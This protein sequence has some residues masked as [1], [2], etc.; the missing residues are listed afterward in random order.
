MTVYRFLGS[1]LT[2]LLATTAAWA[3]D[4]LPFQHKVEVFRSDQ[5]NVIAFTVR[6]EQPFL[7]EEFEKSNYLRLH[8]TDEKA[9]LVYPKETRF[10]Q[11]H[12]EFYGRLRG[13]GKVKLNLSYETVS[14]NLDGS[15]RVSTRQGTIEVTIPEAPA[16]GKSTGPRSIFMK[17]AEEQNEYFAHLLQYY[18]DE[19]FLQYCLLQSKARYGVNP[20]PIPKRMPDKTSLETGMYQLF[21]GS[22][23]MQ[24]SLQRQSL[25]AGS[26]IGDLNTHISA[27][28]PPAL[29]SNDYE[30]LLKD[31]IESTNIEPLVHEISKLIPAEQYFLHFHSMKSLGEALDLTK[32]WGNSLLRLYTV[33]AQDNRLVEKISEQLCLPRDELDQ[34]FADGVVTEVAITGT[35]PFFLEGTDLSVIFRVADADIFTKETNAWVEASKR[36]FPGIVSQSF[37]Y[38]GH[39]VSAHYT[40]DRVVS[41]FAV[42]H[43]EYAIYSNSHRAV[44]RIID[45]AAG[46]A[47]GLHDALDYRYITTIL[48]PTASKES[49][50]FFASEAFIKQLISPAAKVSQKRRLQCFNNLVMINNASLFFRLEYDRSPE[51]LSELIEGRFVDPGKI[52]C[53]HGG[54]YTFDAEGDTCACSLHNRLRYLTPNVELSVLQVSQQEAQEYERYKQR[55]RSFWQEYFNPIAVRVSIDSDVKMEMCVLPFA[56]GDMYRNLQQTVDQEPQVLDTARLAPSAI[57]SV[58]LVPGRKNAAEYLRLIPGIAEVVQEDPTLT[59]LSWLGDRLS[60]NFCDGETIL[61][62]DPTRLGVLDVPFMGQAPFPLQCA[63]A[64]VL[65]ATTLPVYVTIDFE[66]RQKAERLLT[67]FSERIFLKQGKLGPLP[68]ALDAYRLPD[69]KEH[70]MYV[71]DGQVYALTLRLHIALVGDQFVLSTRPEVLREVIDASQNAPNE[72]AVKAHMLVRF[73]RNG[74]ERLRD[75]VE[76]YWAEKARRACHRNIMSIY[77]L[78]KLYDAAIEDIPELSQAKYGVRYF[79]PDSGQYHY[80]AE[81]N[82]VICSVHGNREHSRQ[83]LGLNEKSSFAEFINSV[84]EITAALRFEQEAMITTIT[85]DRK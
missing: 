56:N 51:S 19:T 41:T 17:W 10:R 22:L 61:E 58:I 14:E 43:G 71:L 72:N 33:K 46:S 30:K 13:E 29:K 36:H 79:C 24:E 2:G 23:E 74:L 69:Y 50:Y 44:R 31:R 15:R 63:A 57:A 12:A 1:L 47:D 38:R 8:P 34:L 78:H 40:N 65:T 4:D 80:D 5:D 67:Q 53:P 54:A 11:K 35:D 32:Q 75:N 76:M 68:T 18:P 73:N 77:N 83:S 70:P 3:A 66:D 52:V 62:I 42:R 21:S 48:P 27:L 49:G 37:N 84:N 55:Y 9:Y 60:L 59:D 82:Q 6:L 28:R 64:A 20:P 81:R 25:S 39:Q 26:G 16:A 85:I 45:V 7:A